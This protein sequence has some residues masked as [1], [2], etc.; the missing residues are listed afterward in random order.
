MPQRKQMVWVVM[1]YEII[2]M[3]DNYW[4]DALQFHVSSTLA[5]AEKYIRNCHVDTHSWWQV[6]PHVVDGTD[7]LTEGD[8]VYFYSRRGTRLKA[9]P[10]KKAIATFR[11]FVAR[12]PE[13]FPTTS[14]P[15]K[16]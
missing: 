9:A 14:G 15:T 6:H 12:N 13:L 16:T 1:H 11:K 2:G 7:F 10:T 5:R 4:V 3:P 8:E